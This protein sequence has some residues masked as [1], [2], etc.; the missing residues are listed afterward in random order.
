MRTVNFNLFE[1]KHVIFEPG[2]ATRYDLLLTKTSE[3]LIMVTDRNN[4]KAVELSYQ[5]PDVFDYKYVLQTAGYS[6]GDAEPM[7]I[8][9]VNAVKE[10]NFIKARYFRSNGGVTET[11]A[12]VKDEDVENELVSIGEDGGTVLERKTIW[13]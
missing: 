12:W 13:E 7:A 4:H 3:Q 1:T 6:S 2:N 11:E 5:F 9:L 10:R 8:Y